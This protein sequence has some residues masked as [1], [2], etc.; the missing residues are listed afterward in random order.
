MHRGLAR[1][2]RPRP[3]HR[4]PLAEPSAGRPVLGTAETIRAATRDKVHR[5][6]RKHYVPGGL[7]VAAAG[8][9]RRQ[10]LLDMLRRRMD[11]GRIVRS[12]DPQ[13]MEPPRQRDRPGVIR[14]AVGEAAEDRASA[15]LSGHERARAER[16][17]PV[18]LPDRERR[19]G[20]GMSSRLFRG[21]P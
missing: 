8:N 17:R 5:F 18:P 12:G 15:H 11:T 6:Y 10:E 14:E 4:S 3:L 2:G 13:G 7:V 16:P 20:T 9:L 1:G 21:D 19:A